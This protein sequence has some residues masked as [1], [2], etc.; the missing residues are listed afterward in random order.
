MQGVRDRLCQ[1]GST[2]SLGSNSCAGVH[3]R[4][5]FRSEIGGNF[6]GFQVL[7][8]FLKVPTWWVFRGGAWGR[9]GS[10]W[11]SRTDWEPCYCPQE[12]LLFIFKSQVCLQT[13]IC[14]FALSQTKKSN[15]HF[16]TNNKSCNSP[17]LEQNHEQNILPFVFVLISALPADA[18]L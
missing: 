18:G 6:F 12:L 16:V 3:R 4:E 1:F 14:F 9:G 2:G 15:K 11:E 17:K 10:Y 5:M 8:G 7:Q 13:R